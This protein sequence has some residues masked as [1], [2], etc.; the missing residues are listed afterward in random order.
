[1]AEENKNVTQDAEL[2]EDQLK[3]VAG[4]KDIQKT[5]LEHLDNQTKSVDDIQETRLEHLDSQTK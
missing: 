1:M 2:S 5:R 3:E 4:G